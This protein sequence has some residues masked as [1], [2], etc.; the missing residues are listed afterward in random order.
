MESEKRKKLSDDIEVPGGADKIVLSD[1]GET[2]ACISLYSNYAQKWK[3]KTGEP[4]SE[5]MK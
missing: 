3:K 5:P 4:I 1:D 2:I